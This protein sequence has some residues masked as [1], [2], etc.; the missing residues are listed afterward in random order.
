M[1]DKPD[2]TKGRYTLWPAQ[3]IKYVEDLVK[4]WEQLK[5][6]D[7]MARTKR[8][9]GPKVHEFGHP[10]EWASCKAAEIV[11]AITALQDSSPADTAERPRLDAAVTYL[12]DLMQ[13]DQ[14]QAIID[15]YLDQEVLKRL[16]D[17]RNELA[18]VVLGDLD[19]EPESGLPCPICDEPKSSEATGMLFNRRSGPVFRCIAC[20][21]TTSGD[22]YEAMRLAVA[23]ASKEPIRVTRAVAAAHFGIPVGRIQNWLNRGK[24]TRHRQ[25]GQTLVDLV[26]IKAL[27]DAQKS[28]PV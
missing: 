16:V 14:A 6:V 27:I 4:S 25:G 17:L 11:A 9:R 26:E 23:Q 22:D 1:T 5:N 12:R 13:G 8:T 28:P 7:G 18:R 19:P 15:G 24:L 2:Y 10:A 21:F 3:L 20:Q